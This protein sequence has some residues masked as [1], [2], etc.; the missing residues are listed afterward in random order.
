[1][2]SCPTPLLDMC[3]GV[4][5]RVWQTFPLQGISSC[6]SDTVSGYGCARSSSSGPLHSYC[7]LTGRSGCARNRR[8]AGS[9]LGYAQFLLLFP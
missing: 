5:L 8:V 6:T 2:T 3:V 1:M 9:L 7:Q 4:P